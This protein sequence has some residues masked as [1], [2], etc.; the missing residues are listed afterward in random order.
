MK[1]NIAN[2][3]YTIQWEGLYYFALSDYPNISDWELRK[4]VCVFQYEKSN[5]RESPIICS[6]DSIM[7]AVNN[8]LAHPETVLQA[9]KPAKITEMHCL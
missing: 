8:A 1:V 6:D 3:E 2:H 5:G 4:L 9:Q 7:S